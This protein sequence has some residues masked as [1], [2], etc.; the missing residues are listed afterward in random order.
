MT[1]CHIVVELAHEHAIPVFHARIDL[2]VPGGVIA[3]NKDAPE[4]RPHEDAYTAVRNAFAIARRQIES[5]E[6]RRHGTA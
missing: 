2:C 5:W 4:L 3:V 6:Q 1:S